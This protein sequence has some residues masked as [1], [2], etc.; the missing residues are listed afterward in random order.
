M[1]TYYSNYFVAFPVTDQSVNTVYEDRCP[2]PS[3]NGETISF[4][5]TVTMPAVVATGDVLRFLKVPKGAVLRDAEVSV[6]T[7]F[8]TD[9]PGTLGWETIDVNAFDTDVAFETVANTI[10]ADANI[11]AEGATTAEDYLSVTVG[12]VNTGAA[13]VATITGTYGIV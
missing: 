13:G 8:G 7:S 6:S 5:A 1:A 12:T 10:I 2:R 11:M 9:C 3:R 4:S